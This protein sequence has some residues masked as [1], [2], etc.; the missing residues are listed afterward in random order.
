MKRY[1]YLGLGSLAMC[2]FGLM[3]NWT[4][5]AGAVS[6]E[7]NVSAG[8]RCQR[9][10]S[11]PDL[12][13]RRRCA[14]RVYLLPRPLPGKHDRGQS[15]DSGRFVSD[16]PGGER[17]DDLCLLQRDVQP[18]RGVCLQGVIDERHDVV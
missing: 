8:Q 15:D 2:V 13:L 18:G 7:L 12:F 4:V 11:L 5:F 16:Q 3:Y 14:E 17:D 1:F 9:V 10:L 6:A